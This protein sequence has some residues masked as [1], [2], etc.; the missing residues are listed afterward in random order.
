[1]KIIAGIFMA[2][3]A[4]ALLTFPALAQ[5]GISPGSMDML[6]SEG[7]HSLPSINVRNDSDKPVDFKVELA[8]YGQ[9][10]RGSTEVLEPDT[11]PLS[12]LAYIKFDPAEFYLEPGE[13]QEVDLT[14][15]I[16]EGTEGGRYAIVLVVASPKG[17][18]AIKTVSRLGVLI[19]LT[20]DGSHL[21]Q[22]GSIKLIGSRP[23]EPDKPIPIKVTHANEGNV[24]YKV[25]SSV[26]ISNAQGDILGKVESKSVLVLP[27]YSRELIAEW[28]P[29][30]DLEPGI[31]N[32][33]ARVSLEDGTLLDEA[34]GSFEV[35]VPYVPPSP[36]VSQTLT[37]ASASILKTGDGRI[38]IS[39][40]QGAVFSQVEISLRSY[41]LEEV[42][43]PPPGYNLATTSF[44]VDDLPGLLAKEAT[45]TVKYAAADLDKAE[46]D[47]SRLRLARWDEA[48]SQ[49]TV[50]KTKLDREAMTISTTTNQLSIWAVMV[51]PPAMVN[52]ALISGAAA[53]VIVLALLVYFL[54]VRRRGY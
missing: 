27:G 13:N 14:V 2:L 54:A 15:S 25:Q 22:E 51:A 24:H 29:D 30:R 11:N 43:A 45:V 53:G 44:R 35:G 9:D 20:I 7:Q 38:S 42:P 33:L 3:V 10:I 41:P 52:W 39:F 31:Y 1:M 21:I 49:W 46:G 16:P 4:L 50:L 26:T 34:E 47:A 40:S 36:P 37:P 23:I 17:E 19:R 8:G 12:A 32:A 28:I 48:D 5:L 18:E 6:V